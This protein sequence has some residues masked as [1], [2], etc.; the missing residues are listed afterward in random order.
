[1]D[2]PPWPRFRSGFSQLLVSLVS[3]GQH[4]ELQD[5]FLMDS[6]LSFLTG[7]AD[8]QVRPFRHTGTLAAL[9]VLSSLVELALGLGRQQR[10][11]ERLLAAERGKE[12]GRR[13]SERLESLRDRHGQ[14][15][16]QQEE[17]ELLMNGIFKGVFVHRYRDVVPE[18]RGLCMEELGLWVRRFPESFLTDSHLK[19]LGWTLHDKQGEVRLSCVRAL[20]GIY[21][22]PEMAPN[23][24]L[25]TARFKP[26]LV[27]MAHDKEPQVALEVLRLLRAMDRLQG[28]AGAG[29]SRGF[30]LGL[31]RFFLQAELHEHGAYLVDALWDC[32]GRRLRDWDTA[33]G[34][35]LG[36]A[37]QLHEEKAL[38]QIL[39]SSA[40]RL[41]QGHPPVGRGQA[42]KVSPRERREQRQE[43]GRLSRSLIPV[44]PQLLQKFSAEPEAVA[45]LLEPLPHLELGLLRTARMERYLE[46]VLGQILEVFGKHSQPFP[47]LSA[48]SRAL[49]ALSDPEL[50]LHGLGDIARSRLGD[51]LGDRCHLQVTEMLQ[52][53]SPDEEDVYALAATLRRLATLF[54]DHDLTP[55]GLFGPLS[56]LLQRGL[57]TG[58]VPE[59]V[60]IPALSC[61]FFHLFWELSRVPD[62]GASPGSLRDLRSRASLL[63]SLCQS[64]LTEPQPGLREKAF[65]VLCDLLVLLGPGLPEPGLRLRPEPALPGLLGMALLDL[66]FQNDPEQEEEPQSQEAAESRLEA[67]QGRRSLL[68]GFCRLL[69]RGVLGLSAAADV[70][71]RYC[72][73][74]GDFGD[75]I[76][77][78]LRCTRDL[79]QG[80]WARTVLLSLQQLFTEQLLHEGPALPGLGAVRGLGR[81]LALFFSL[82]HLR[83]R[84]ALLR[85]HREGIQFSLQPHPEAA[86]IPGI[87]GIPGI[88]GGLLLNLPFLEVLSEFSPR[89]LRP[90]RALVLALLE[91]TCR[92][93][94]LGADFGADLGDFGAPLRCYRSSLSPPRSPPGPPPPK[95][96]RG[97]EAPEVSAPPSSSPALT[98]TTPRRRPR[99]RPSPHLLSSESRRTWGS[100]LSLM[101]EEEEEEEEGEETPNTPRTPLEQPRDLFGSSSL[102]FQTF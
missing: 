100:R 65:L 102:E 76:R 6:L 58:E 71:K 46:Q 23:L 5:G 94:G 72:T 78:L 38:V 10:S 48:A 32:A 50:S 91:R 25:F 43:R 84:P 98:S 51:G 82:G 57:D 92:E 30:L 53:V 52:A 90:D 67:L 27:A 33:T 70:F 56:Q 86:G 87:S 41:C 73:F 59:Q 34:M 75:I 62:S 97:R 16:E 99:P 61:L 7:L 77:E 20:Q 17:L 42:R 74:F 31:A 101:E 85:L 89:L 28:P 35:L 66:V 24:E 88:P 19:Y 3:R 2:S 1:M 14:L 26:R 4:R 18:I 9:K 49:R 96:G 80:E 44:L 21:G 47:A 12:P 29:D 45:A 60:T 64:C 36:N 15:R 13:G 54:N 22:N 81:R 63:L 69:L 11:C 93:R 39:S 37:L 8:S 40:L 79:D 55:W 83:A 95:R 68:A